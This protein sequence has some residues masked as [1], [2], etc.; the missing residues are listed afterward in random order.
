LITADT[1]E[2]FEMCVNSQVLLPE[3]APMLTV[4]AQ[5]LIAGMRVSFPIA[6]LPD[7]GICSGRHHGFSSLG[8]NVVAATA[9]VVSAIG[10]DLSNWLINPGQ[11]IGEHLPIMA[12]R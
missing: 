10:G 6:M 9:T 4:V 12:N 5:V 8:D 7:Y 11:G 3:F 2:I 1:P